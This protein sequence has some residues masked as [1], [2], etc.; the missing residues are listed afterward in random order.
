M[1]SKIFLYLLNDRN[2]YEGPNAIC[3][4]QFIDRRK[5]RIPVGRRIELCPKLIRSKVI[6][7]CFEIV[8]L[9]AVGA[10][11]FGIDSRR[12]FSAAKSG[13]NWNRWRDCMSEIYILCFF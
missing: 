11:R 12:K 8:F 5:V 1:V 3:C 10:A 6:M 2:N 9:I 7:S 4:G 13:P